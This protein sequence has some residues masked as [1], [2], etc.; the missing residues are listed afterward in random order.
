MGHHLG[1]FA[2]M[3]LLT[4]L[5]DALLRDYRS[6]VEQASVWTRCA[7]RC[8]KS[9][10]ELF[11]KVPDYVSVNRRVFGRKWCRNR[12]PDHVNH[13]LPESLRSTAAKASFKTKSLNRF[14]LPVDDNLHALLTKLH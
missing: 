2:V 13:F 11:L 1:R 6:W 3:R 7:P 8:L 10:G 4:A 5:A 12:Y 14:R 9:D